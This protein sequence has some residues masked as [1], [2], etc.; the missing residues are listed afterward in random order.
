MSQQSQYLVII[1]L[2]FMALFGC[3]SPDKGQM[4]ADFSFKLPSGEEKK[5]SDF[6]GNYVLLDFWASWCGPCLREF[7]ELKEL[8]NEFSE[9]EFEIISIAIEKKADRW[10]KAIDKYDLHWPNH[11]L[12]QSAF[13]RTSTIAKLYGVTDIPSHFLIDPKG[14]IVLS[15]PSVSEVRQFMKSLGK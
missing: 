9:S 14:E 8:Y 4:A 2:I 6:Q 3:K 12:D 13:V 15:Q 1:S 10:L 7:P 5:L 11:G